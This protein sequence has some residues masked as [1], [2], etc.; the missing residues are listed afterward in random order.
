LFV[1]PPLQ[2]MPG[3]QLK[4]LDAPASEY[5]PAGHVA[6][7]APLPAQY[8]PAGHGIELLVERAGQ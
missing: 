5:P 3:E 4:Q 8:D 7:A 2:K 6:G 1:A